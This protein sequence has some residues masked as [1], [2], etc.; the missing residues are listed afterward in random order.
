MVRCASCGV[1]LARPGAFLQTLGF[2]VV[3][4]STV[5]FA[6]G[7]VVSSEGN[8]LPLIAG[9]AILAVGVAAILSARSKNRGVAPRVI[10]DAVADEPAAN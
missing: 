8:H 4:I 1:D 6:L 2:V 5:P 9:G 10:E 3:A 7:E